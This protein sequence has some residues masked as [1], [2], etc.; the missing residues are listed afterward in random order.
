MQ[1]KN[2]DYVGYLPW[3]WLIM[4]WYALKYHTDVAFNGND[5]FLP[6]ISHIMLCGN[7]RDFPAVCLI[8]YQKV[9]SN[10]LRV[11]IKLEW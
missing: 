10:V 5:I 7:I 4:H 6:V 3:G 1:Y 2:R 8:L 9:W 11:T